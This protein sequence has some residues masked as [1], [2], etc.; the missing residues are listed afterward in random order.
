MDEVSHLPTGRSF[1]DEGSEDALKQ[2]QDNYGC[3]TPPKFR[4]KGAWLSGWTVPY[5]QV[6]F[7]FLAQRHN[8]LPKPLQL[9]FLSQL[10][11]PLSAP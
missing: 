8:S 10:S 11:S 1:E 2:R 4:D 3:A 7:I 9:V 5:F 6:T